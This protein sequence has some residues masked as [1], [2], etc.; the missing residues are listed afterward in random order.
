MLELAAKAA[1]VSG[2]WGEHIEY[3]NGA[4]DLRDI[5]ILEG[6]EFVPWNPLDDDGDALRLAV[7][8]KLI[9]GSHGGGGEVWFD[10]QNG[11]E[12]H[13]EQDYGAD[14][15]LSE[16]EAMRLAI[17]RAAAEIGRAM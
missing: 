11:C 4:V 8:L 15:S 7:K 9:I 16:L 13:I 14:G 10:D 2:G 6:D 12:G 5:W 3:H 1:G 17:V